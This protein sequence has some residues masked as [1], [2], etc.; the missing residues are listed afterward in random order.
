MKKYYCI[1]GKKYYDD[2]YGDKNMLLSSDINVIAT[3]HFS[4]EAA[5]KSYMKY[6]IKSVPIYCIELE[7]IDNSYFK[8]L[9]KTE[10]SSESLSKL[11]I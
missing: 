4:F 10:H 7:K 8:L 9:K 2:A 11:L 6:V 5:I 3:R 1:V